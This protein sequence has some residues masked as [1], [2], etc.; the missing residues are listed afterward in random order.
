M[1]EPAKSH[2]RKARPLERP[3]GQF[4]RRGGR[5][6]P[7]LPC[8]KDV[9][10]SLTRVRS[11]AVNRAPVQVGPG[12]AAPKGSPCSGKHRRGMDARSFAPARSAPVKLAACKSAAGQVGGNEVGAAEVN[13][14]GGRRRTG[15]R[16]QSPRRPPA[17][18]QRR[19]A[20]RRPG[21]VRRRDGH[22][23]QFGRVEV[24]TPRDARGEVDSRTG[25]RPPTSPLPSR[26]P[27]RIGLA[28][29]RLPPGA[30]GVENPGGGGVRPAVAAI[31][32]DPPQLR[33]SP[34]RGSRQRGDLVRQLA[35]QAAVEV[36]APGA[37]RRCPTR[38]AG[39]PAALARGGGRSGAAENRVART[40]RRA[41]QRL[42]RRR[43]PRGAR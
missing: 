40:R 38:S 21:E 23:V 18:S 6:S 41:S 16:R 36:V 11:T 17:G 24:R 43:M 30:R 34:A 9:P 19:P 20:E 14:V 25:P 13:V 35:R 12:Q 10:A 15:R 4:R 2:V 5:S 33:P 27:H 39:P 32:H 26:A 7:G 22:A 29:V 1:N 42:R 31:L 28:A 37:P 8:S 3:P